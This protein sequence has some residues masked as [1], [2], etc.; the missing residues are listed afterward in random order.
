MLSPTRA[1]CN[2]G[3]VEYDMVIVFHSAEVYIVARLVF[4]QLMTLRL[5]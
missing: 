2:D 4:V 5:V 3:P 1:A